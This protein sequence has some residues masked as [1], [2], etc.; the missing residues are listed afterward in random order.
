MKQ[1]IIK[2]NERFTNNP[3]F[4]IYAIPHF[5]KVNS[6]LARAQATY[7]VSSTNKQTNNKRKNTRECDICE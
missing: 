4:G 7:T 3:L 5:Q 2:Q 1:I 6:M